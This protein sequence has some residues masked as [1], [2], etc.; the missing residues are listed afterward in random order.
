MVPIRVIDDSTCKPQVLKQAG[1]NQG[2][3]C[4]VDF[5]FFSIFLE[6]NN[7]SV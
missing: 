3:E 4:A 7:N 2:G 5:S 1:D 6:N